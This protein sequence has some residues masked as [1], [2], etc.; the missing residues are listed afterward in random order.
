MRL[1]SS[2]SRRLEHAAL[3][4]RKSEIEKERGVSRKAL[5]EA[6]RDAMKAMELRPSVR[7][8][9]GE[10]AGCYGETMVEDRVIVW[11]S[12]AYLVERTGLSERAV[13]Y[14]LSA[15]VRA[16]LVVPKDSAN[17]KRF[18][19]R[20]KAGEIRGAFGFDLTALYARRAE[21]AERMAAK[22]RFSEMV[23]RSFDEIT[24]ERRAIEQVLSALA[25]NYPLVDRSAIERMLTDAK[26]RTPRRSPAA[27]PELLKVLLEAYN[28]IR[29][30][31]E[32]T[33]YNAGC[34]GKEC[35]HIENINESPIKIED[36]RSFQ[37]SWAE[38]E[39]APP[40]PPPSLK[41]IIEACPALALFERPIL[42][43][44]DLIEAGRYLRASL[45]AHRS[46][47]DDACDRIGSMRA[48]IT[49]AYVLQLV[50]DD[51]DSGAN[52][53]KNPG[54]YL[55]A[56]VGLVSK[57]KINLEK[58]LMALRRRHME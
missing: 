1:V 4:A 24:I 57:L 55:R 52:R 32:T 8:V 46:V 42:T 10:L 45:G 12:N 39:F 31:A 51:V 54:G 56:T 19:I 15:L 35:Q 13:R 5:S 11:P 17:G 44:G 2:G 28:A 14:S 3:V 22:K 6:A 9:L 26:T 37:G 16:G 38:A 7:L 50:T 48:A 47:W 29:L 49:V 20:N 27:D 30:V 41:L 25:L 23:R 21:W 53:I 43:E 18:A 58:E 36:S 33:F 40:P 34:G